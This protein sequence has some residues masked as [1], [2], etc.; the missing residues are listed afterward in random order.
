[1]LSHY[2]IMP[3]FLDVVGEENPNAADLPGTSFLPIL[4]GTKSSVRD[5]VVI[6][7]EY[8]PVRMI[9]TADWKYVHRY[10]YGPHELY[11]LK[12]DPDER[13]NLVDLPA[14]ADRVR[15]MRAELET[16]F[17]TYTD[18]ALDGRHEGVTGLGQIYWAGPKAN[19]CR[20]HFPR[21]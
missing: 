12:S 18:P 11:D 17:A 2:D 14:Q 1:M 19:G 3:T 6:Y 4:Q 13:F 21:P 20:N 5:D 7:D 9:R 16:W 8:G 15:E 10:P